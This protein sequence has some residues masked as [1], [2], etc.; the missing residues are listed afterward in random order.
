MGNQESTPTPKL[1]KKKV[2]PEQVPRKAPQ[3]HQPQQQQPQPTNRQLMFPNPGQP[4]TSQPSQRNEL[5][6]QYQ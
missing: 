2:N 1:V 5:M 3:Q 6:L 4:N